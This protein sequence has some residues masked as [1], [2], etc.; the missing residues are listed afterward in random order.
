MNLT[1]KKNKPDDTANTARARLTITSI[2]IVSFLA[3]PIVHALITKSFGIFNEQ[4]FNTVFNSWL[5]TL[6]YII[7]TVV[8]FYFAT[9]SQENG[10]QATEEAKNIKQD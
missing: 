4:A 2:I 6:K 10:K 3:V 8:T 7:V 9:K 5:E 1:T